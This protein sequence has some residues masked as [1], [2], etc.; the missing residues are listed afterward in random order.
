LPRPH[1]APGTAQGYRRAGVQLPRNK[2]KM[3]ILTF[4]LVRNLAMTWTATHNVA[5]NRGSL[6]KCLR[7]PAAHYPL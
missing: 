3:I 5:V 6:N 1:R 7:L 2:T 4:R